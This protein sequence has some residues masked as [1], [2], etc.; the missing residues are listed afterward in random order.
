M[1][2]NMFAFAACSIAAT[3]AKRY[4]TDAELS[5]GAKKLLSKI[6]NFA[7]SVSQTFNS[8]PKINAFKENSDRTITL[9]NNGLKPVVFLGEPLKELADYC[10]GIF[11][12]N[13]NTGCGN[14]EGKE[15]E[16]L[17]VL[18]KINVL[19]QPL[20][21]ED[22]DS[23][24]LRVAKITHSLFIAL[25]VSSYLN[26]LI[27]PRA[28]NPLV[29]MASGYTGLISSG[30]STSMENLWRETNLVGLKFFIGFYEKLSSEETI[31]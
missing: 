14:K 9:I 17:D 8:L 7:D 27:S 18:R 11:T 22:S 23:N 19:V 30:Y 12:K 21:I 29:F 31:S 1:A 5:E 2:S 15:K 20:N 10:T 3:T 24:I 25:P 6:S 26:T 28:I 4:S 13:I 16:N